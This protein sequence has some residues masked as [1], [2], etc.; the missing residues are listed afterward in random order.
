MNESRM[1]ALDGEANSTSRPVSVVPGENPE[2]TR[3][4]PFFYARY[5]T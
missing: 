4:A 2:D 5:I 3:G 1:D